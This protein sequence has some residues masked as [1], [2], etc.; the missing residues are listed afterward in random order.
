MNDYK[1]LF[2][3]F[4]RKRICS[5]RYIHFI[6]QEQM[7][8]VLHISPRSYLDQE[9]GRYGFSSLSLV[10]YLLLLPEE[11]VLEFLRDLRILME[12]TEQ[13]DVV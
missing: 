5:Y 11:E 7:A 9:H 12:R 2:Q 3:E 6:T 4:L 8:E 10:F 13:K 1:N